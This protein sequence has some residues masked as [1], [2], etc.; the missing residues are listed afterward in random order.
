MTPLFVDYSFTDCTS[1]ALMQEL[2]IHSALTVDRH[3][4][5][6]GFTTVP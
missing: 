4:R 5:Q 3:F 2:K 1:F 6:M